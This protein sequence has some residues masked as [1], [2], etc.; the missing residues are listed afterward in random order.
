[1]ERSP[2][3]A[4]LSAADSSRVTRV[5]VSRALDSFCLCPA[6]S[7]SA[8][9]R[10]SPGPLT[11]V[12]LSSLSWSKGQGSYRPWPTSTQSSLLS[13]FSRAAP[14]G[15]VPRVLSPSAFW[16]SP[17]LIGMQTLP[18]GWHCLGLCAAAACMEVPE[19]FQE[20]RGEAAASEGGMGRKASLKLVSL[21]SLQGL[22]F[23]PLWACSFFVIC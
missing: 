6:C 7:P 11:M 14:L 10:A 5:L 2:F 16:P 22:A 1:M 18:L 9:L 20:P 3:S 17:P 13:W 12:H 15:T 21:R 23:W 8:A 4:L 19:L